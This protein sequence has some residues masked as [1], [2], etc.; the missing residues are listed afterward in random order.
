MKRV[1]LQVAVK[2]LEKNKI[3]DVADV[4]R[5]QREIHILKIVRHPCVVQLYEIIETQ[6]KLYLIMEFATGGE[7]FDYIVQH[8]RVKEREACKFFQNIISGVEYISR[9]NVVHRDLKP[10]NLLLDFDKQIKLVDFGLSNT[11]KQGELLK[12]ACGSP[13]YAAPEMIAGKK[14][15]GTNV[16]IWSCGVILFALI[17]GYLPFEDP[18]TSNLYKKILSAD[19]ELPKFVSEEAKDLIHKILNTDPETRYKISDIQQH[20]WFKQVKNN[21]S[22]VKGTVVG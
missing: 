12:T 6:G 11:Y 7:L 2:I 17:C 10:E 3:L 22:I 19:F 21:D 13:C 8:Q 14:Y 5:V 9:L 4:E 1:N 15:N 16:D 20:P 18:V